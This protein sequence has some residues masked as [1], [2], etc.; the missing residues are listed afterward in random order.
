[1]EKEFVNWLIEELNTRGWNNSELAR[2]ANISPSM[3]SVVISGHSKPGINFCVGVARAFNMSPEQVQRL[4]GLIPP[5]P[6][7]DDDP[8]LREIFDL[9]RQLTRY[10][11]KRLA[12]VARLYL[13]E[14]RDVPYKLNSDPAPTK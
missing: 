4:A 9:A 1:V 3:V 8:D 12:R 2:R 11:R 5:L 6:A 13:E 7:P 10:E 14:Q